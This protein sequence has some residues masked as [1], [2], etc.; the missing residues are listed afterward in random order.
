MAFKKLELKD[1]GEYDS[2]KRKVYIDIDREGKVD[3]FIET[4]AQESF[5][6]YQSAIVENKIKK[7][8]HPFTDE[9]VKAWEWRTVTTQEV[10]EGTK[11]LGYYYN[12][13]AERY[14]QNYALAVIAQFREPEN[15][16]N[17]Q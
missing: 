15:D 6:A 10:Y 11:T 7:E 4:H 16:P 5:H 17:P 14:L 8:E 13:P 1:A 2:A 3:M 9:E 12:Q